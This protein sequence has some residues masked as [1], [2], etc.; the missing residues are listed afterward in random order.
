MEE[1]TFYQ[2]IQ[3]ARVDLQNLEI[4][5]SGK[6]DFTQKSGGRT[7]YDYYELADFLPAINELCK[8]HD[9]MT[10]FSIIPGEVEKAELT[11]IDVLGEVSPI[12]FTSPTADAKSLGDEL[13]NLGAKTTYLR[14]YLMMTAFEMVE[15]DAVE[16]IRKDL[17]EALS[18]EDEEKIRSAKDF[19]ELT[20][21]CGGLKT[22][23]KVELITPIFEEMKAKL[24]QDAPTEEEAKEETK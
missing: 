5:K 2:R 20:K 21:I 14:R 10:H 8:K 9:L 7:K 19:A 13:K 17:N 6:V 4:K 18:K 22:K 12:V 23:Y 11:I 24:E 15:S 1:K 16:Q 3:K